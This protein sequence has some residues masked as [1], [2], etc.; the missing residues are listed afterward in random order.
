MNEQVIKNGV[1][2]PDIIAP[3][4]P[5]TPTEWPK[6]GYNKLY[7]RNGL[8]Y[9]LNALGHEQLVSASGLVMTLQ[10]VTSTGNT[11]SYQIVS[12]V[13]TGTA[14]FVVASSTGI[15]KLNA[16]MLDGYHASY[17]QSAIANA[18]TGS[19][20]AGQIAVF[21]SSTGI[22]GVIEK[23]AFNQNF[24]TSSGNIKMDGAASAG[25]LST[26]PRADHIHP[27]DTSKQTA[28]SELTAISAL[29]STGI[30][31]RLGTGSWHIRT[32]VPGSSKLS[33]SNADGVTAN[34]VLDVVQSNID[35]TQIQNIGIATHSTIDLHLGNTSNPHSTTALQ[36][37]LGN[38]TDDA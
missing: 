11:T 10:A 5:V 12:T 25:A 14:P 17:F 19:G 3:K 9:Q 28:S 23:T 1:I 34:P 15:T 27:S 18:I 38:V 30:L 8:L 21:V 7:F 36:I 29:T 13:P 37:G 26:I 4:L 6:T 2:V 33:I 20:S 32:L 22:V 24:E 16:D 31:V 35:H